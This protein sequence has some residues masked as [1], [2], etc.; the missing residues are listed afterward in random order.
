MRM[1]ALERPSASDS[2]SEGDNVHARR[3]S[4]S[5]SKSKGIKRKHSKLFTD[6][7]RISGYVRRKCIVLKASSDSDSDDER[8]VTI[9]IDAAQPSTSSG[10]ISRKP[11]YVA[12]AL[13]KDDKRFFFSSSSSNSSSNSSN[14]SSSE[15]NNA[16]GTKQKHSK[17]DS[18]ASTKAQR[19][20]HRKCRNSARRANCSGKSQSKRQKLDDESEVERTASGSKNRVN[21]NAGKDRRED[22]P[23]TPNNKSLQVPCTPDSGIKSGIS[24]TG[25]KNSE[26]TRNDEND[27]DADDTSSDHEQKLKS[28]ECFRKKVEELTRRS[29]RHRSTPQKVASTTSDSSD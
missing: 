27:E 18:D 7:R 28:L 21:G 23:S 12:N 10:V 20:K 13:E 1:A 19:R 6:R 4:K 22:G 26:Q 2:G 3:R 9:G 17:T 16:L 29:Y 5:K 14:S 11:R 24:T 8:P 15:D 25:G